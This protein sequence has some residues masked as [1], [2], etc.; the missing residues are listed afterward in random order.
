[1]RAHQPPRW[2]PPRRGAPGGVRERPNRHA[3]KACEGR[4]SVG[5][6]PT[7]SATASPPRGVEAPLR[8]AKVAPSRIT[9]WETDP[10]PARLLPVRPLSP[11]SRDTLVRRRS[12]PLDP[13]TPAANPSSVRAKTGPTL[14]VLRGGSCRRRSIPSP[15]V[16]GAPGGPPRGHEFVDA[17]NVG[18]WICASPEGSEPD[19]AG[20]SRHLAFPS[21]R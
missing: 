3:W 18:P 19:P 4:P 20:P 11:R 16:L 12:V 8:A 7:S 6:N 2:F 1:M 5:S 9:N 15:F 21:W 10:L 14:V 17:D 13:A